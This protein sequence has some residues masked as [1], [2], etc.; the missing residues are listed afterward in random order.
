MS[1]SGEQLGFY[2]RKDCWIFKDVDI[3]VSPGEVLGFS[4][5]SGCG[6]TTL[7]RVLAGYLTPCKGKITVDNCPFQNG[8]FRPVQLIYQHP[9]KAINSKWRMR[10]VLTESYIPPQEFLDAL[11]IREEWMNRWPIELSGGELQRFCI[12]RALNPETRYLIADEMT[13]MLDAITQA[14]IWHGL[15]KIC[16]DRKIG[17]IVV[18]HEKSLLHRICDRIYEIVDTKEIK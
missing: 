10:E 9:E 7:A 5:Y 8:T 15:L 16:R 2:Y 1:L 13:T 11:E 18:S 6:K 3:S 12:A 17:L 14:K 4:G